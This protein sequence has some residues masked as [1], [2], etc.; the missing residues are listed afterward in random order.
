MIEYVKNSG[1]VGA[2]GAGFPTHVKLNCKVDTLIINGA[3]CE[4]LLRVDQQIMSRYAP[5]LIAALKELSKITGAKQSIIGLKSHYT[6]AI[7]NLSEARGSDP[8]ILI[9]EFKSFYP[10]GDE[11][12]LVYEC[13]GRVVPTGGIPLDVSVAVINT[14]TLLNIADAL[15]GKP[16]THKFVTVTGE[17]QNPA[18]FQVPIGTPIS[19]LI[20]LAVPKG[21]MSD[22]SVIIGGPCMGKLE[23]DYNA[24]VTKTTSG[25]L[26]LPKNSPA[27]TAKQGNLQ[28]DIKLAKAVCC[29]CSY[30][31][32]LCPRNALGLKVEP[33]KAMRA[34]SNNNMKLLGDFNGIFS[35]CDCG[36]CS[37]YACNFGLSPSRVM[38]HVK[39]ELITQG[40]KP[41]KKTAHSPDTM[42]NAK[43]LP[44]SRLMARLR[45]KKYDVPAPLAEA[46]VSTSAVRIPLKMH[47]GVQS[48]PVVSVGSPVTLGQLIADIPENALGAKIHASISGTV[49]NITQQYIE[50]KG[51]GK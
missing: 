47:I 50:I 32:Q 33:H 43:R 46:P 5:R 6:Q 1:V 23:T 9:K 16:V 26:L 17:V 38:Q 39:K 21:N 18:T 25:I 49:T 10:L 27:V 13:T 19:N 30:C 29:Q 2:G 45:L 34:V 37:L 4:P 3:E 8:T 48:V 31:T 42:L 20:E 24:P 40:V 15:E 36:I 44:T 41:D 14:A 28:R 12:T 22:Y 51:D 11:Q 7:A 35:C